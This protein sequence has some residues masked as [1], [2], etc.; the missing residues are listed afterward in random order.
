MLVMGR[1]DEPLFF[2][3]AIEESSDAR[4]FFRIAAPR[5]S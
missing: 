4:V 5:E 3:P 2:Y 1:L